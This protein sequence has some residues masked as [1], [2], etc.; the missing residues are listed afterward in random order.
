MADVSG[1]MVRRL[2][3]H[4]KAH[5][6]F[7]P[8]TQSSRGRVLI[9][10]LSL[11]FI[12][13]AATLW[14]A[15]P[16]RW[17]WVPALAGHLVMVIVGYLVWISTGVP[18]PPLT[19]RPRSPRAFFRVATILGL[20]V[21]GLT[22]MSPSSG[23]FLWYR[24]GIVALVAWILFQSVIV[25]WTEEFYFRG[26][27]QEVLSQTISSRPFLGIP[28]FVWL[29]AGLFG[30]AHLVNLDS[31]PLLTTLMQVL[32]A[33]SLGLVFGQYYHKTQDL[34]GTAWL[35]NLFDGVVTILPWLFVLI[36]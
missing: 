13:I 12:I 21:I 24:H 27:I 18:R 16:G 23:Q 6:P 34:A 31:Q 26:V 25:G 11:V 36:K 2:D 7:F 19:I 22:V 35:H 3:P 30:L 10:M 8:V 28:A 9:T 14:P 20:V 32:T 33:S 29:S 5:K 1:R 17:F 15:S 4:V